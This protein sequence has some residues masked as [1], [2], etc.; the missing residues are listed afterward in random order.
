MRRR[1]CRSA[2]DRR[3]PEDPLTCNHYLASVSVGHI[4]FAVQAEPVDGRG[5]SQLG[6]HVE[7][8]GFDAICVADHPGSTTSPFASLAAL[9]QS[10]STLLLGTAVLN[11]G[12]WE[13]LTL[14]SEVATLQ[15][16]SDARCFLGVGAGHTPS[17]WTALGRPYP[18]AGKRVERMIEVVEA[19]RA[20]LRGDTVTVCTEHVHLDEAQLR[21]RIGLPATPPLLVGGNGTGVLRYGA[22][23]ADIVELTGLGRTLSD[24]HLHVPEWD[25]A[26]VDRRIGLVNAV[27]SGRDIRLGALMQRVVVTSERTA[28]LASFRERLV[29][30]MGDDLA[31]S[32]AGLAETPYML[33]GT[34]D[35]MIRQLRTNRDRWGMTRYTVRDDAIEPLAPIIERLRADV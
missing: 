4:G 8:S 20:L 14:A 3:H 6:R 25:P 24:G 26:A 23:V 15:L 13:P 19:T 17:E 22:E 33:V 9:A 32:L 31:P 30:L 7:A 27:N 2:G 34:E 11:L 18:S 5:W 1:V 10:T 35:E 21:W 16:L 28:F 29:E 12:T